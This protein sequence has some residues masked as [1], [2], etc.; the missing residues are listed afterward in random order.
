MTK[1]FLFIFC[2]SFHA[3]SFAQN[4][5][6]NLLRKINGEENKRPDNFWKFTTNTAAP[7]SLASPVILLSTGYIQKDS[8]LIR[9]G[10]KSA[11]AFG[12]NIT[13]TSTLKW[14]IRRDRPYV[15]YS[16]IHQKVESGPYSFPSGHTSSAFATA[17]LLTLSTRKWYVAAPSFI[18]AG[19][20]AYSR[21]YLG[22]HYPSDIFGGI[23]IG[24]GSGLLVWGIDRLINR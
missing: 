23:V 1:L 19:T 22:V 18:W 3:F 20:V 16:D 7:I 9:N 10:W 24:I 2:F 12:L 6:I 14:S 5:D 17:T 13:L 15:T 21:M 4:G 11:I 8:L